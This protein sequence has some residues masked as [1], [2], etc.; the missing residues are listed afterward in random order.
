MVSNYVGA[1][2]FHLRQWIVLRVKCRKRETRDE[3]GMRNK[4]LKYSNIVVNNWLRKVE[5]V[6]LLFDALVRIRSNV[7]SLP[8]KNF[9]F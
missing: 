5:T 1:Y 4:T 7:K 3:E 9:W 8:I 2:E 6:F